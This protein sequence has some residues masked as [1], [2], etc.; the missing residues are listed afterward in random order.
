MQPE[1]PSAPA[2]PATPEPNRELCELAGNEVGIIGDSYIDI[3]TFVPQLQEL[4]REAG[5]LGPTETYVDH[6]LLGA[7]MDGQPS[8]PD[9]WPDALADARR[10]GAE[11]I[12]LVIMDGGGNDVLLAN[13]QC[14]DFPSEAFINQ[15]CKDVVTRALA[16]GEEL[17]AQMAS[18]GVEAMIYFFYPH[19]PALSLFGGSNPN[20]MVDYAFPFVKEQCESQ[21]AFDCHFVDLRP[22]FDDGFGNGRPDLIGLDGV[23]PNDA[24]S[25]I[26]AE[27]V[28]ALMEAECL[29]SE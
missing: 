18:D 16:R 25:A 13:R 4:A 28:W 27:A 21:T 8:I 24:G 22:G 20:T 17:F 15:P 3:T 14:L 11:K 9:Q 10:R 2:E 29:G 26:M 7:S 6:A 1:E 5:A 19:L 23:H 12:R